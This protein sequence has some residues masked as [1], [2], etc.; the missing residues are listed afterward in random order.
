MQLSGR[1]ILIGITGGIAAYK[2]AELVRLLKKHGAEVQVVMT[3]AA[4]GFV[5]P[6]T[7]QALS[8]REVRS[9]LFDL[10]QESSMGHID[11]ARWADVI[12]VAPATAN[13]LAQLSTGS[14]SDLLSTLVLAAEVPVMVAPAMNQAMWGNQATV[15]NVQRL[16]QRGI[17]CWGPASGVQACGETGEGRML[18]PLQL[19]EQLAEYLSHGP[20][21]GC[22]VV[23]TAGP[24]HEPIDPVRYI[25]N[26]SSG[27]MGFA[28]AA[29]FARAGASVRLVAGPVSLP[30]PAGVARTDVETALQMYQVVQEVISECDLFA[31]CAAVADYRVEQ[32]A[33]QKI[34]KQQENLQLTLVPNPDILAWVAGQQPAPFTLGFAAET[35]NLHENAS[36]KRIRKGVDMIAANLVGTDKGGFAADDNALSLF[37]QDGSDEL[38]MMDKNLLATELVRR[39]TNIYLKRN[40]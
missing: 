4:A 27:K 24:T 39:V 22:R 31:A 15:D 25:G 30:T 1:K 28:L 32:A 6:M 8:G 21:Q 10:Q 33:G 2:S 19:F 14:A 37:W 26:R 3:A 38:P 23:V 12:L 36:A 17:Q 13:F 29:A 7:L 5:T 35:E 11:L 20:L 16:Q 9:E 18:E 34:K 40:S